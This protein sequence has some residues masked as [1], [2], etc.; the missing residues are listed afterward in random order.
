MYGYPSYNDIT[1]KINIIINNKNI[2]KIY[3]APGNGGISDIAECVRNGV[4]GNG[5]SSEGGNKACDEELSC[6]KKS[7][8]KSVCTAD[9]ENSFEN[10][11]IGTEAEKPFEINREILVVE[12]EETADC[13]DNSRKGS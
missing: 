9:G 12:N 4:C 8:F 3:C 2:T 11:P 1:N 6:L 7:V 5:N 13:P 10:I